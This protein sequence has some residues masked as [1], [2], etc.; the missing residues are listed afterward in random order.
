VSLLLRNQDGSVD[1]RSGNGSKGCESPFV[2]GYFSTR[3]VEPMRCFL[4]LA[5]FSPA[6]AEPLSEAGS[7]LR[8]GDVIFHESKSSQ[9]AAIRAA[10]G[11]RYTHMGLIEVDDDGVWVIE[12]VQPVRR[13]TLATWVARGVDQHAVVKRY[14]DPVSEEEL[15]KVLAAAHAFMGRPY[16]LPFL[17]SDDQ[18]Y[19]SELVWKAWKRGA[20]V[21]LG[22]LRRHG[23]YDLTLP[24]VKERL[25]TRYPDGIPSDEPVIA[26]SD[27][28]AADVLDLVASIP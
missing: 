28:F 16:D 10:T 12:A 20:D 4:L 14:K 1:A 5:V 18:V 13:T 26:P 22:M 6:L 27:I 3:H 21:E 17:W 23:D 7:A 25:K 24:E 2:A 11:S 15:D 19:C 9:A 8:S